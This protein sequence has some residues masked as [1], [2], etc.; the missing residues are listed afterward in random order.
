VQLDSLA[1]L[2]KSINFDGKSPDYMSKVNKVSQLLNLYMHI[3]TTGKQIKTKKTDSIVY[4]H[5]RPREENHENHEIISKEMEKINPEA[6]QNS[7]LN[8]IHSNCK[9]K[10]DKLPKFSVVIRLARILQRFMYR[11]TAIRE[12]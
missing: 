8:T 10:C 9:E 11:F 7:I 6:I 4:N 12:L 5:E 3:L 2:A 1:D